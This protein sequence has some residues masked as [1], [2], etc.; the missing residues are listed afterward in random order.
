[1]GTGKL[2]ATAGGASR[3]AWR[4]RAKPQQEGG[5]PLAEDDAALL[6]ELAA[7]LLDAGLP[8]ARILQ[9]LADE[10]PGCLPLR[11]VVRSLELGLDWDRAWAASP[12][13]LARLGEALAF[14]HLTGAATAGLLRAAAEQQ[15]H[16]ADRAAEYRAA[17][18]G[19]KMVVPLGLCALPAF[20][21]LGIIPVVIA[22]LPQLG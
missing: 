20:I 2:H 5:A 10:I 14:A 9:C 12:P 3:R 22:L 15:R 4:T 21:C 7:T 6:H 18:L 13:A 19:V 17:E 11:A 1:M 8:V 16:A